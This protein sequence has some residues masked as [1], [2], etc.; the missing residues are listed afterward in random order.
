MLWGKGSNQ[1][2]AAKQ[3]NENMHRSFSPFHLVINM[4][5][6]K[7]EHMAQGQ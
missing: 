2:K 1:F 7:P 4:Q 3:T 6:V 5:V